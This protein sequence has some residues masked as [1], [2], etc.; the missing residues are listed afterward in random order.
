MTVIA[1][2]FRTY[3]LPRP[4]RNCQIDILAHQIF[5]FYGIQYVVFLYVCEL[6]LIWHDITVSY[7]KQLWTIKSPFWAKMHT[8]KLLF[9]VHK[10][11]LTI[12]P[13]FIQEV[14]TLSI[15]TT[16]VEQDTLSSVNVAGMVICLMGITLHVILKVLQ[17]R[18]ELHSS[19]QAWTQVNM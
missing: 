7:F 5:C 14:L 17:M 19:E 16:V 15:A 11:T 6:L 13:S 3:E 18:R 10:I 9:F 4:K 1:C 2:P 12:H 8:S